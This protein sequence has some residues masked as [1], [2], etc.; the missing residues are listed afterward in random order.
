VCLVPPTNYDRDYVDKVQYP[1][2]LDKVPHYLFRFLLNRG[3]DII[4]RGFL[5]GT[6]DTKGT[7][8]KDYV[9]VLGNKQ[10]LEVVDTAVPYQHTLHLQVKVIAF[11]PALSGSVY[12]THGRVKAFIHVIKGKAG[13]G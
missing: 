4:V 2:F 11:H 6:Q 8:G 9:E 3:E 5:E 10:S 12:L 7:R 1:A 13:K